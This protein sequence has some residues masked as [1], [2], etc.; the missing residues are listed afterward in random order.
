MTELTAWSLILG[1][2]TQF[3]LIWGQALL[4]ALGSIAIIIVDHKLS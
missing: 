1:G 3:V 4:I 2:I